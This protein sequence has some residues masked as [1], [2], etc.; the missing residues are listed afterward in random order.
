MNNR[1][2]VTR[3][4]IVLTTMKSGNFQKITT[5]QVAGWLDV[6]E[7]SALTFLA[8]ACK[9]NI[10]KKMGAASKT[11][12]ELTSS[13]HNSL[14]ETMIAKDNSITDSVSVVV[15]W[16]VNR[17]NSVQAK[18][19]TT[20]SGRKLIKV[21]TSEELDEQSK[22]AIDQILTIVNQNK[23]L[24]AEV[25]LL[26]EKVERLKGFEQKYNQIKALMK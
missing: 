7:P 19:L 26:R 10:F 6:A 22:Q 2:F 17:S 5:K 15:N 13:C 4:E 16:F 21:K 14:Q 25:D 11:Y 3:C 1:T 24:K 8:K 20:E 12:Y 9:C 23:E 18:E